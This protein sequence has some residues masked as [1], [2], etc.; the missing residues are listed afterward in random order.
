MVSRA[1]RSYSNVMR[2]FRDTLFGLLITTCGATASLADTPSDVFQK[3]IK[4][5]LEALSRDDGTTAFRFASPDIQKTFRTPEQFMR[6]VRTRFKPVY[7]P[8]SYSFEAPV[9]VEGRPTQ[10]VR[11][12]G[13]NGQGFFALYEMERQEDG[14]WRIGGVTLHP[15]GERG[16]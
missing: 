8:R 15:N 16:T 10:P 3:V 4:L 6:M 12:I 14:S 13:P 5:Q 11:L 7:R 9:F 2:I 1:F